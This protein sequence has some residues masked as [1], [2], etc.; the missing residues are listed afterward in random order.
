MG[1]VCWMHDHPVVAARITIT[2]QHM[3]PLGT[4]ATIDAWIDL[5][6][7]RKLSTRARLLD[8]SGLVLADGEGLFVVL[9]PD[10]LDHFQP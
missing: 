8:G 3:V 7:G 2:F 6:D 9:S 5:V 4:D 10:R 1:A